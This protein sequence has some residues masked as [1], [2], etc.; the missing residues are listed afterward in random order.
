MSDALIFHICRREAWDEAVRNG[1]YEG[2]DLDRRD[3]FI[4]FSTAG[5]VRETAALY[6]RGVA[7]L[8]LIGVDPASLG[9][10]LRWERSRDGIS[11]PHLYGPLAADDAVS[12]WDLAVGSDGFHVFPSFLMQIR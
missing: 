4:H 3:G 5:R 9:A 12:V 8:V 1:V 6:L 11:F 7:E 2:S 10:A